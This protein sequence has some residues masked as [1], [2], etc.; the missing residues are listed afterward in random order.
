MGL[1]IALHKHMHQNALDVYVKYGV[2]LRHKFANSVKIVSFILCDRNKEA[3][4]SFAPACPISTELSVCER[5]WECSNYLIE[6]NK[7][8]KTISHQHFN[9]TIKAYK[10][11]HSF[12]AVPAAFCSCQ[13]FHICKLNADKWI[14]V[15]LAANAFCWMNSG[16]CQ[17][18]Y[19]IQFTVRCWCFYKQSH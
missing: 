3:E 15:Y 6:I 11:L 12:G 10:N 5:V 13:V 18:R 2:K 8:H 1:F 7:T 9:R 14:G 16:I 19:S 4:T 17:K